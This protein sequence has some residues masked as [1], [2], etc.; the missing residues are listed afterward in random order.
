M[1][2]VY[3]VFMLWALLLLQGC[4]GVVLVGAA[5]TA[6]MVNDRRSVGSQ[7]DDQSL[8]IKAYSKLNKAK[9]L[10]ANS[11]LSVISNNGN[12]LLVGQTREPGYREQAEDLLK[13][14]AGV[15]AIYNEIRIN[16]PVSFGRKSSD[17]WLTT[18]VK[19]ALLDTK[20]VDPLKVKVV[21]ENAEVFL[22]GLVTQ[23]EAD[24]AVDLARKVNGVAR[25]VKVFEYVEPKD[26]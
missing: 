3:A 19:A 8:E 24:K 12:L 13:S 18:K 21:T 20:D 23:A 15:R 22:I 7:I 16:E 14:L 17:A 25:V 10:Q 9:E 26:T 6:V 1:K 5:T 4:A 11:N 2:S